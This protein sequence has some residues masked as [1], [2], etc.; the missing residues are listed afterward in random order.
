MC[1]IAYKP[2]EADQI[3]VDT[4]YNMARVN[5]DGGGICY[6][7]E[8]GVLEVFKSLNSVTDIIN[9]ANLAVDIGSPYLLHFRIRTHG[10]INFDNCQPLF[11]DDDHALV[12][13]GMLDV[14]AFKDRSDSRVFTEDIIATFP[15]GWFESDGVWL[16]L[17]DFVGSWNKIAVMNDDGDVRIIN[18]DGGIWDNGVWYSNSSYRRYGYSAYA[19]ADPFLDTERKSCA[20]EYES[21]YETE[22]VNG[23]DADSILEFKIDKNSKSEFIELPAWTIQYGEHLD[24]SNS[25]NYFGCY[26]K[27]EATC[28]GCVPIGKDFEDNG[29]G[30]C[31]PLGVIMDYTCMLCGEPISRRNAAAMMNERM[32]F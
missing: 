23:W 7:N 5:S 15:L 27:H 28:Y 14:D 6:I 25:L 3:S 20:I 8:A 17:T 30:A 12:H 19:F 24:E 22:G 18:E 2:V 4:I 1:I 31:C 13:N 32:I 21:D 10:P 16:I 9:H 26:Y 29:E 11:V